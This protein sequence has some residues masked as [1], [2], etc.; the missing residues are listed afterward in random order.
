MTTKSE[1]KE[2]QDKLEAIRELLG[3][4]DIAIELA[5]I[6]KRFEKSRE[7]NDAMRQL[8]NIEGEGPSTVKDLF[9][10]IADKTER[11]AGLQNDNDDLQA[12]LVVA[13]S[14]EVPEG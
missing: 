3:H 14:V 13:E 10:I 1:L 9:T 6:K 11:I 5:D 8:L 7:D 4:G 12:A 2:A